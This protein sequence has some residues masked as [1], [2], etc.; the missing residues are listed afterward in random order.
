MPSLRER[1]TPL[2]VLCVAALVL[3]FSFIGFYTSDEAVKGREREARLAEAMATGA[4]DAPRAEPGRAIPTVALT[5]VGGADET[6]WIEL[7]GLLEP[8]RATWVAAE[9][10][11]RV[12]EVAAQEHALVAQGDLLVQLDPALARADVIRAEANH[13][14]AQLELERQQKLGRRSATSEAARD[15]ATAEERG[16]YAALLEARK[17][18]EQT[19]IRAP[20]DGV[21]NHLDLDPGAYVSPGTRIAEV[22]D[23]NTLELEVAVGDREIGAIAVGDEARVRIDPVG[24]AVF[25]GRVVRVARAPDG[26]T[27]RYP[28]V[29]ALANEGGRILPGML[30]RAELGVGQRQVLRVPTRAVVREFEIDYVVVVKRDA[31]GGGTA[32]RVRV[33]T[34]PVPFRPDWTE[35]ESGLDDGAWI[36]TGNA[37]RLQNGDRV[38]IAPD[39]GGEP[40]GD[41]A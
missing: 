38:A 13:R 25:R 12:T 32:E 10:A 8:V 27:Q 15:R 30:A 39:R 6:D 1:G 9:R 16:A 37:G 28:V 33:Q 40:D 36:V 24:N 7:S 3:V 22:L 11:G 31:Q 35:I 5:R 41:G 18:L 21:V 4:A 19:R 26:E 29:V 34:R 14:L 17:R 2:L 23:M 20:F